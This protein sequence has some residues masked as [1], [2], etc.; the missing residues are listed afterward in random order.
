MTTIRDNITPQQR[1][2][3]WRVAHKKFQTNARAH[4]WKV[5]DRGRAANQCSVCKGPKEDWGHMEYDCDGVQKWIDRLGDVYA[6][7]TR[8]RDAPRWTRPDRDEW[9]LEEDKEMGED[10]MLVIAIARWLYHKERS[11][12][13]HRQ[14]RRL[15]IDRLEERTK[16]ELEFMRDKER[17]RREKEEKEEK[18]EE[19]KE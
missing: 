19:K 11:A 10:K 7:Y 2:F 16:E 15:D 18:K 9:R 8:G 17:R 1:Q 12:L 5:D 3:W 13:V 4:K 6:V 14:R